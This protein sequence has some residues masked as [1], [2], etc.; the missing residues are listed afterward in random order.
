MGVFDS[1]IF[2]G[3]ITHKKSNIPTCTSITY[4]PAY[5]VRMGILASFWFI[6]AFMEYLYDWTMKIWLKFDICYSYVAGFGSC[7]SVE[8]VRVC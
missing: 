3:S 5:G 8:P 4:C 2:I 6:L 1:K 7:K